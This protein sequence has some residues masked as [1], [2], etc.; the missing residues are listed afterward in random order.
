MY[1]EVMNQYLEWIQ[2]ICSSDPFY[3]GEEGLMRAYEHF[4]FAVWL[5]EEYDAN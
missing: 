5:K 3:Q 1:D 2:D 4:P